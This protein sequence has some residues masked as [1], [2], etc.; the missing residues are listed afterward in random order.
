[1]HPKMSKVQSPTSNVQC[2]W[3]LDLGPWTLDLGLA[4]QGT[5]GDQS[6][7][8]V[9]DAPA[10]R[11]APATED[12]M[13][14]NL[15]ES[16]SHRSEF[17]RRGSFF[18][19]TTAS[20]SLLFVIAGVV[21]IYAYD[22]RMEDQSLELVTMMPLVDLP[23]VRPNVPVRDPA[24]PRD[25]T[26]RQ[27]FDERRVLMLSV[28]RPEVPKEIS[29]APNPNL[30]VRD[31]VPTIISNRDFTASLPENS[32][33]HG[34]GAGAT[35]NPA[36]VVTDVGIPPA[37]VQKPKPLMI[38]KGVITSDALSLPKPAYP[39]MAKA[40]RLQGRVSVQVLIDETGKVTSARAI[41]GPPLLRQASEK[42]AYQARFSPTIL[43]DQPVKVSGVI[44]YNFVLQQ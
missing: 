42:A 12:Q 31:N 2:S 35:T 1:M 26:I 40:M 41:D 16:S 38:S 34:R 23:T 17:K 19:F 6:G 29:T 33:G 11:M 24:S 10:T 44:T 14:N 32:A 22:A 30:P 28:N 27:A 25:N 13:F 36:L 43:S 15:I 4:F 8:K 37:P 7:S 20:Y 3:T 9:A 5:N 18:L 39:E 21:S